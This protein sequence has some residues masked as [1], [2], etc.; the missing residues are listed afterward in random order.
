MAD[1][2]LVTLKR[3]QDGYPPWDE[4]AIPAIPA[5]GVDLYELDAT[6]TFARGLSYRDLVHTSLF[7]GRR[8]IDRMVEPRGHSTVRVVLFDDA[9]HDRVFEVGQ[10]HGAYVAHT[11]ING[12]FALDIPPEGDFQGLIK[13]LEQGQREGLWDLDEGSISDSHGTIKRD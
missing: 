2:L 1:Q 4:E 9:A 12:L 7:E 5:D 10:A 8:Y 6:P 3:D 11:E 13:A